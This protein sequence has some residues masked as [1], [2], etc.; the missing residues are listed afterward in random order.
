VKWLHSRTDGGWHL[1]TSPGHIFFGGIGR[2]G[3]GSRFRVSRFPRGRSLPENYNRPRS[4]CVAM[5]APGSIPRLFAIMPVLFP[6]GTPPR[7]PRRGFQRLA[8]GQRSATTGHAQQN[9]GRILK[10]CQRECAAI[11]SGSLCPDLG[12]HPVVSLRSTT[13]QW[14]RSPPGSEGSGVVFGQRRATWKT[15][16]PKMTPDPLSQTRQ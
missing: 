16:S 6:N 1:S 15:L 10:G 2:K 13:G 4:P 3:G 14:L 11:P 12:H 9:P 5:I 8:G 7:Q